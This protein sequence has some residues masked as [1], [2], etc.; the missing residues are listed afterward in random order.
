MELKYMDMKVV[1]GNIIHPD[2]T[3]LKRTI[4]IYGTMEEFREAL[5]F[6]RGNKSIFEANIPR[7]TI[8]IREYAPM[9][10]YFDVY[11]MSQEEEE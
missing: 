1:Y 11:D 9:E 10:E 8:E 3:V 5:E 6:H 2:G 7:R 4:T